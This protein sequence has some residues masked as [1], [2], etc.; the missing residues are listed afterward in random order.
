ME[1]LAF[2]PPDSDRDCNRRHGISE[3]QPEGRLCRL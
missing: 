3:I 1:I 2:I